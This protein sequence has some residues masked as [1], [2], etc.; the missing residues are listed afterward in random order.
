[1]IYSVNGLH[2]TDSMVN[3]QWLMRDRA[4]LTVDY[5]DAVRQQSEDIQ[6][7]MARRV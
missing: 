3:G 5:A 1:L 6:R 2:V 4:L 7:L